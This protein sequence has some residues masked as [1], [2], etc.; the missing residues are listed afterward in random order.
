VL[1]HGGVKTVREV[2]ELTRPNQL[3]YIRNLGPLRVAEIEL[4]LIYAGFVV[5]GCGEVDHASD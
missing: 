3:I 5:Q 1:G 4:A 2:L